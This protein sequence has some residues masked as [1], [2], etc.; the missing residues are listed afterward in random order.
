MGPP[1][2]GHQFA[3]GEA[4]D[5]YDLQSEKMLVSTGCVIYDAAVGSIA[6]AVGGV[7]F[8]SL[9]WRWVQKVIGC[10]LRSN[11]VGSCLWGT[12]GP[13]V[14]HDS[15]QKAPKQT[16]RRYLA[17]CIGTSSVIAR[18]GG[19]W[20]HYGAR[21]FVVLGGCLFRI[22]AC[23]CGV[24]PFPKT[25]HATQYTRLIRRRGFHATR[26]PIS[27]RVSSHCQKTGQAKSSTPGRK[28]EAEHNH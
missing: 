16:W 11:V 20:L 13:T 3:D 22:F 23:G 7:C 12:Q 9:L 17:C 6:L 2:C 21:G 14:A 10:G 24:D 1:E 5:K 8:H 27:R 19:R 26:W 18:T 25:D 15:L 28:R 4:W